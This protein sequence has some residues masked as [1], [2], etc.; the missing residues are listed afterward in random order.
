[1]FQKR[2]RG[3][4]YTHARWRLGWGGTLMLALGQSTQGNHALQRC[5]VARRQTPVADLCLALI[6]GLHVNIKSHHCAARRRS[7]PSSACSTRPWPMWC[8]PWACAACS[9]T[10][11]TVRCAV[12]CAR[13]VQCSAVLRHAA[14]VASRCASFRP[15]P[16]SALV[17]TPQHLLPH[18]ITRRC[19]EHRLPAAPDPR[20]RHAGG[21]Q[22]RL[23]RFLACV[24]RGACLLWL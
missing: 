6:N 8:R 4:I 10:T 14:G 22:C 21:T 16:L 9:S 1:M 23:Q 13:A 17:S 5:H 12:R 18:P 20:A 19:A 3:T 15:P 24:D 7:S 11:T 2:T